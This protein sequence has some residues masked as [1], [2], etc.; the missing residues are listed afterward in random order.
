MPEETGENE[1]VFEILKSAKSVKLHA[2]IK[3]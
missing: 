1:L 2:L 3:R